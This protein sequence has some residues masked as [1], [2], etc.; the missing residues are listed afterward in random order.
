MVALIVALGIALVMRETYPRQ[1]RYEWR[2]KLISYRSSPTAMWRC[3]TCRFSHC[4]KTSGPK[5]LRSGCIAASR[6]H[7]RSALRQSGYWQNSMRSSG[8]AA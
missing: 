1:V 3:A 2:L 8:R 5:G 4:E 7:G 6:R